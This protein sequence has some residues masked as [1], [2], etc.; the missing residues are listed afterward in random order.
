MTGNQNVW[1]NPCSVMDSN[2]LS[3]ANTFMYFAFVSLSLQHID[4]NLQ[5][6]FILGKP[7]WIIHSLKAFAY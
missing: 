7:A 6:C 1:W 3:H 4:V 2:S 5:Q